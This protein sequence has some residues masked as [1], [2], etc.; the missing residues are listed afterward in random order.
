MTIL[1]APM[2]VVYKTEAC[3]TTKCCWLVTQAQYDTVDEDMVRD[4]YA[5]ARA[6]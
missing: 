6:R 2:A 1:M 5:E 3:T 4:A